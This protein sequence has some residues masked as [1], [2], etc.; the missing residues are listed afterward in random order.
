[1]LRA[2]AAHLLANRRRDD[3][4]RLEL[5]AEPLARGIQ[6]DRALPAAA[7]GDQEGPPRG[8]GIQAGRMNLDAIEILHLDA[9]L[10]SEQAGVP[11]QL[12]I[13]GRVLIHPAD[14]ARREQ[15]VTGAHLECRAH[16]LRI[17]P[18]L[19]R[20]ASR[21]P[22]RHGAAQ[23]AEAAVLP[24]FGIDDKVDR[25]HVLIYPHVRKRAD[26]IEKPG[27]DRPAR[28][29]RLEGDARPGVR[30]LP[31]ERER[32]V[33]G[34][35]ELH[36]EGEQVVHDRPART[37]HDVDALTTVRAMAGTH[38]V[39]EERIVVSRLGK[40]A[41]SALGEH[42]VALLDGSLREH[43]HPAGRGQVERRVQPCDAAARDD[44]VAGRAPPCRDSAAF[45]PCFHELHP[46]LR[47]APRTRACGQASV[48]PAQPLLRGRSR[49]HPRR[50]PGTRRPSRA[51]RIPCLRR[52][53][54]CG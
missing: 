1:M 53:D 40:H 29:I 19:L 24:A 49:P 34:A 3:V 15:R 48:A 35:L 43:H 17:G 39:L 42:R 10:C 31:G 26:G 32:P 41:D 4:A 13:V 27:R 51:S 30:A 18:Q 37:D 45:I 8:L 33:A 22:L 14:T 54:G 25:R 36:A 23:Q 2:V 9:V 5:V 52:W 21:Q 38:R 11:R 50:S 16:A 46:P 12:R 6:Q 20:G 28:D 44:H 47:R 7:L